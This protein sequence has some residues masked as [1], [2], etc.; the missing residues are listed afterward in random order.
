MNP[1]TK[2]VLSVK[3]KKIK[4]TEAVLATSEYWYLR[5]WD[6]KAGSY[7]YPYRETNRQLYI[8]RK[9]PDGW[10]VFENLRPPPRSSVPHRWRQKRE[11]AN[12][13]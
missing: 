6:A 3:V 13:P 11:K 1:S 5:W 8:V 7:V 12:E 4:G 10:R 9:E 2:R